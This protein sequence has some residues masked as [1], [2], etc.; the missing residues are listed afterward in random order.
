MKGLILAGGVGSRLRPLTHTSAKQL[1]PVAN[2]PIIVYGIEAMAAAG[3]RQVGIVVGDTRNE[4]MAA[5]GDGSRW[6]IDITYI[7]QD[8]PDGLAACVVIAGDFL[9]DDDFVMYLGDNLV[10]DGIAPSVAA[11]EAAR[12]RAA[13]PSFDDQSAG[14]P[15]AQILLKRVPDPSQ[16]GVAELDERG[17]V[18]R[19]VEK[20]QDPPSDLALVGVYLFDQRVHEAVRSI[21]PSG[22]NELEITDA[23]QWLVDHG[24]PVVTQILDGWWLDTGKKDPLLE[25]NRV[26]LESI[27]R[28]IDGD[29]DD[30]SAVDGR[31]VI[32]AGATVIRSR[33]RGPA[34]IGRGARIVDT[35]IGPFTAIGDG[36]EIVG[37]EIDHSVVMEN[38]RIVDAGRLLDS[39]IGREAEITRTE[40]TPKATRLMLGDH[41]QVDLG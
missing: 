13:M 39:L 19:L 36:C 23:I 38:T 15:A 17:N 18:I 28:R 25:A 24:H 35:F 1:V 41:C 37:S 4:I 9:G 26:I 40:T 29:V 34:I 21:K 12:A 3:I 16:F 11:F 27:E 30:D 22:R 10:E 31:V 32:E 7:H 2:K 6:G 8:S 20:P 14:A 5:L 33:V